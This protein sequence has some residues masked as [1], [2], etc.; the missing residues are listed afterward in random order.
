MFGFGKKEQRVQFQ[1]VHFHSWR[2]VPDTGAWAIK[3]CGECGH[4]E[5]KIAPDVIERAMMEHRAQ[6]A[7]NVYAPTL[8]IEADVVQKPK[9]PRRRS[10][11]RAKRAKKR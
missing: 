3:V 1:P 9:R 8:R 11:S 5:V 4:S 2:D 7:R 10:R 6:V